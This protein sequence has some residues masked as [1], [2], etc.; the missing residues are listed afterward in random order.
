M[1]PSLWAVKNSEHP[2]RC[3]QAHRSGARPAEQTF[4]PSRKIR[5]PYG[6]RRVLACWIGHTDLRAARGEAAVG[7]G[8][9][10]HALSERA[11]DEVVLLFNYPRND[12]AA[13]V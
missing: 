1:V 13:Y 7:L 11:F 2:P 5:Y 10:A 12:G 8:P 6:M 9:I 4:F 3:S